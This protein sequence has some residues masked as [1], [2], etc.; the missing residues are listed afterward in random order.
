MVTGRGELSQP[1]DMLTTTR[2]VNTGSY[3]F[4]KTR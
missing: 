2:R 3:R 1:K 4:R